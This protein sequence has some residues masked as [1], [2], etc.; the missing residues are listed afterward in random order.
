MAASTNVNNRTVVHPA[1]GGVS[2]AFPDVCLTPSPGG[3]VPVPYPNVARSA[4]LVRGSESVRVDGHPVALKGSAFGRSTGDEPGTQKGVLSHA[5][6]GEARFQNYSFDVK[7]EGRPVARLM[8]PMTHNGGSPTNTAAVQEM[9]QPLVGP[10]LPGFG[11]ERDHT[12]HVRFRYDD[13]TEWR[14]HDER[15]LLGSGYRLSGSDE[16]TWS[17]L[18]E[19]TSGVSHVRSAGTYRLSLLPFDLARRAL[20]PADRAAQLA[21][22]PHPVLVRARALV[23]SLAHELAEVYQGLTGELMETVMDPLR[24][25]RARIGDIGARYSQAAAHMQEAMVALERASQDEQWWTATTEA[26]YAMRRAVLDL[27]GAWWATV[28]A[29]W[30]ALGVPRQALRRAKRAFKS[31]QAELYRIDDDI[32]EVLIYANADAARN[33]L[34]DAVTGG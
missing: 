27:S 26:L 28:R 5:V 21:A 18:A 31:A 16:E 4:D 8:D 7:V 14:G 10:P 9:Q 11:D 24:G 34:Y 17:P 20:F 23:Q 6:Q 13:P 25:G 32:A 29:E 15:V 22:R 3:P 1:S 30:A 33:A 19:Y 12:V 2:V